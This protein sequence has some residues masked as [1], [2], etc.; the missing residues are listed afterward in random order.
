MG[1]LKPTT[2]RQRI[3]NKFIK[4]FQS[5]EKWAEE[6][7][8]STDSCLAEFC[9]DFGY[10]EGE[11]S[12]NRLDKE[13]AEAVKQYLLT[14]T[15]SDLAKFCDVELGDIYYQ[16]N[17]VYSVS[18]GEQDHQI[19][20]DLGARWGKLTEAEKDLVK[21]ETG[22][23][24]NGWFYTCHNYE[25]FVL[26]LDVDRFLEEAPKTKASVKAETTK[27]IEYGPLKLVWSA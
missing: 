16:D 12:Y 5:E 13:V 22:Y 26:I 15:V 23:N 2:V 24:D 7:A 10:G 25:R 14:H 18:I 1:K 4:D 19:S 21:S 9:S 3:V 20:D 11:V 8:T 6:Y 27:R 17:E